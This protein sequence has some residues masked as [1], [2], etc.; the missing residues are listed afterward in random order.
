MGNHT[1]TYPIG[2][3]HRRS[4]WRRWSYPKPIPVIHPT[5]LFHHPTSH[6][7][8]AGQRNHFPSIPNPCRWNE[9]GRRFILAPRRADVVYLFRRFVRVGLLGHPYTVHAR[10]RECPYGP[11]QTFYGR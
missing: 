6:R 7:C 11:T 9:L 1:L 10:A 2:L 5:Y 8:D 4:E 3:A